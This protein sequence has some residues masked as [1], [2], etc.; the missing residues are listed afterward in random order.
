MAKSVK[1]LDVTLRDGGC[2]ID[3]N[4]GLPYMNKI[5]TALEESGV[6]C[7][8]LGYID[9]KKGTEAGRTQYLSDSVVFSNYTSGKKP[10]VKYFCMIDHGKYDVNDLEPRTDKTIDGIRYCFHKK[11]YK[12]IVP[13]GKKILELGYELYL[14]PMITLRYSDAEIIDFLNLVNTEFPEASGVYIVDSFGEMRPNDVSR[15]L[16]LVDHTLDVKIP[17]G[18]HSHNNLQLSY[19]NA[20]SFLQYPTNRDKMVDAS[21]MGMGK[22][23]GNLNTELLLE[24]MNLF[25]G[26][27]YNIPPLLNVIDEVINQIHDEHYWGYAIEYYLSSINKCTPSYAAHFYNKHMLSVAEVGEILSMIKDEKKISFDKAYAESL[28]QEYNERRQFNDDIEINRLSKA[29]GEKEVV[30]IAPGKSITDY[31]DKIKDVMKSKIS[32]SLNFSEIYETDFVM[33]T[34]IEPTADWRIDDRRFII[35]SNVCNEPKDNRIIIDYKRWINEEEGQVHDSA[36]VIAINLLKFLRI[37]KIYLA[38]FDGFSSNI[39]DNYCSMLL[40]RP[41]KD[42]LAKERNQYFINYLKSIGKDME[43][44]FLTPSIYLDGVNE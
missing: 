1:V 13:M 41:V 16:T 3:F 30:L 14:Q 18:F 22:G 2:V 31:G 35:T 27:D 21:I 6:N 39:N 25:Y 20:I 28:Y 10:G 23:A 26:T 37:K 34:K 36:S 12:N 32:I 19:S 8:E 29:I 11:D 5:K 4:F 24:H 9:N 38:G 7:I 15:F 33:V 17:M 43:I 40:R 44:E 42:K